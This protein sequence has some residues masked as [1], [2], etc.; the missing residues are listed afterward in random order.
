MSFFYILLIVLLTFSFS[1][2]IEHNRVPQ[3]NT[4]P[5]ENKLVDSLNTQSKKFTDEHI[6]G[7]SKPRISGAPSSSHLSGQ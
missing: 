6:S 5:I 3:N 2:N 7:S 4:L 1:E